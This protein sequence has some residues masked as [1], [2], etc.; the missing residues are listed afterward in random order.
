[1]IGAA[2]AGAE[3]VPYRE[4]SSDKL[5]EGIKQCLTDEAREAAK[6]LARDIEEEGD[7]SKNAVASFHRSLALRGPKSMR[8][9]IL[10]DRV[11][12][13]TLKNLNLRLSALAT[14]LLVGRKKI[15]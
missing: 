1:M 13:W 2:G 3:P 7:G 8:C 5:A 12:V 11:A 14:D 6:K 10:E 4:L 9:S 15:T